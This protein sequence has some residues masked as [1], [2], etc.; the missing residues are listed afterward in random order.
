MRPSAEARI[1]RLAEADSVS[2]GPLSYY[3]KLTG[4][5]GLPVFTGVQTCQP[6][7]ATPLHWHPYVECLFVLEGTLEA[8]LEGQEAAPARLGPGD[9]IALPAC[10]PHVFRNAGDTTLRIVGIHASPTRIVHRL[11]S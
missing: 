4:E 6:G 2:F 10:T 3:Q 1:V 5:D 9:M 11:E 7:Y 8:W